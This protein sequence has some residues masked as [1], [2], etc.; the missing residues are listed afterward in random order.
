M[1]AGYGPKGVKIRSRG[2]NFFENGPKYMS[3]KE[4]FFGT[5][6]VLGRTKKNVESGASSGAPG[7]WMRRLMGALH[8]RWVRGRQDK[9]RARTYQAYPDCVGNRIADGLAKLGGL[10]P[11]WALGET[12]GGGHESRR[13]EDADASESVGYSPAHATVYRG[14][15][16]AHP[17]AFEGP[18]TSRMAPMAV[19][20]TGAACNRGWPSAGRGISFGTDESSGGGHRD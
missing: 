15:A 19:A 6:F 14:R 12:M 7:P 17:E 2:F 5:N 4:L 13:P 3:Q 10:L 11:A 8:G 16:L 18:W 20:V 9:E 1:A